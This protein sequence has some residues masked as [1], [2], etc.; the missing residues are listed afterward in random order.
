MKS[1]GTECISESP[2]EASSVDESA[3]GNEQSFTRA[4]LV[5]KLNSQHGK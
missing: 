4:F 2:Q 1:V 5:S 3:L